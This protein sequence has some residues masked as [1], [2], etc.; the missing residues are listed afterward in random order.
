MSMKTINRDLKKGALAF[1]RVGSGGYK[2]IPLAAAIAYGRT[3]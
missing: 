3:V 1:V 2:R